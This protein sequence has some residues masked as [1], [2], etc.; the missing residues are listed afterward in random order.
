MNG[1]V[2]VLVDTTV[3]SL[4]LRRK[5]HQLSG[6]ETLLASELTELVKE[7]RAGIIGLIRQELLSGVRTDREFEHLRERLIAFPDEPVYT[8]DHEEA[9]KASNKC[10]AKG[11]TASIVDILI[12]TVAQRRGMAIFTADPDFH[13]YSRVLT[14][15]LHAP[16]PEHRRIQ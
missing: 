10:Q 6:R 2:D 11:I 8:H 1:T 4:A 16:R 12:C 9:A 3:W 7:G 13:H 5:P 15:K 14:L